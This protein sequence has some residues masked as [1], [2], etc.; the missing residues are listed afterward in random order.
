MQTGQLIG[1]I[2][3]QIAAAGDA[4]YPVMKSLLEKAGADK[5]ELITIYY[6]SDVDEGLARELLDDLQA[7]FPEQ[8]FQF[9]NGGQPLY[10]Y[11]VSVE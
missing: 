3:D 5:R 11:I 8:E 4:P 10:P 6:G 7:D 2:D 9:V 1:L